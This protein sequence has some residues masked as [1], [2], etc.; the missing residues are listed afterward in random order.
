MKM[1]HYKPTLQDVHQGILH[2]FHL[3]L[4]S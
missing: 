4:G 1:H 3:A 2:E